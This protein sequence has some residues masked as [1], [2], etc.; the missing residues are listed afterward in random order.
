VQAVPI[1]EGFIDYRKFLAALR[2]GG[3]RGSV[4]YEMCSALSGGGAMENLDRYASRFLEFLH[5][6]RSRAESVAAD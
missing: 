1:D 6:F 5:D 2:A 3:F 4:A